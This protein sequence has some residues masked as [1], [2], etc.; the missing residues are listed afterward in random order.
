MLVGLNKR[1]FIFKFSASL[2]QEFLVEC[3]PNT[4]RRCR[5]YAVDWT[6]VLRLV[7]MSKN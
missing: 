7:C 3:I 6:S 1:V 4:V 2:S 5:F